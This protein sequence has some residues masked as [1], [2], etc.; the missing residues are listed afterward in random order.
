MREGVFMPI[1]LAAPGIDANLAK[2]I[3]D[4]LLPV[5]KITEGTK[6]P[7]SSMIADFIGNPGEKTSK[8]F[9]E[10]SEAERVKIGNERE[11]YKKARGLV[12]KTR[13]FVI[14]NTTIIT[15]CAVALLALGLG[16]GSYVRS[17]QSRPNTIGMIPREVAETYYG[18]FGALDHALMEGCVTNKAG[19]SDIDVVVNLFVMTKV[20]QAYEYMESH[21][22]A[23]DWLEAGSP[24]TSL[25][26]FGV[27]DLKLTTIEGDE[28]DGEVS[29]RAEYDLWIPGSMAED[30]EEPT[31]EELMSETVTVIPPERMSYTDDLKITFRKDAWRISEIDR[32]VN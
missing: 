30:A 4:A 13:R 11:Q 22:S 23:E 21:I 20:R 16:V 14:R 24:E 32:K 2:L 27:T 6:R 9:K 1:E 12:V 7:S 26:I 17:V 10:L 31:A 8:W 5:K 25:T 19:K 15:A 28:S 29:I 18:A 3:S